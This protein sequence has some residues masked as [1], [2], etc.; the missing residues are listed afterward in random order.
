MNFTYWNMNLTYMDF[1]CSN[2]NLSCSNVTYGTESA[3]I[4]V[5]VNISDAFA[6]KA[7]VMLFL[8]RQY[9]G[10]KQLSKLTKIEL[11]A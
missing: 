10:A 1:T 5:V 11:I 9:F 7:T 3:D 4:L 2:I 8:V 6:G